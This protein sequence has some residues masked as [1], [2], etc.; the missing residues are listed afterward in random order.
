MGN[1]P[2]LLY[3]SPFWPEKSGISEYSEILLDGLEKYFNITLLVDNYKLSNSSLY[4]RFSVVTYKKGESYSDYDM[5]LY[6]I[7]NN[8]HVHGYMVE[9]LFDNPGYIILHD[10]VLFYLMADYYSKRDCLFQKI[11]ELEGVSG[12]SFV[13][14][15]FYNLDD[16]DI[17]AHKDLPENV[18][19]N[20]EI[21][22]MSQGV[23]VHSKHTANMVRELV[24]DKSVIVIPFVNMDRQ[25]V[26]IK[27]TKRLSLATR[28]NIPDDAFVL[29][30]VG[31][32]APTK[33]N[34]QTCEA[35][36][37]F[38][39]THDEKIYYLMIGE[40]DYVD[41]YLS[42]YIIKTGFLE[43]ED[44]FGAIERSNLIFNLRFPSYGESSATVIQ[45]M[46]R[47]KM[48]VV[49]DVS[50]FHELPD[51]VVKKI[52]VEMPVEAMSTLIEEEIVKCRAV[53]D[54]IE[55]PVR[56]VATHCRPDNVA[57]KILAAFCRIK[58]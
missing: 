53:E 12:I 43:P 33:Q 18:P 29:G 3:A 22:E 39:K 42:P 57:Q 26:N 51:D 7:G 13:K 30:A 1:K 41:S 10:F 52:P 35:V 48:C 5:I 47:G 34:K 19:L 40:G 49:T 6:N 54:V 45:C 17:L 14:E 55:E 4:E 28:Y 9:A 27:H 24:P 2:R 37:Y 58:M 25:Q 23:F 50:W 32:I 20:K 44:Y 36:Q 8:P 16:F 46:S 15:S 21:L 56:Y 38:N 11:Y 31:F